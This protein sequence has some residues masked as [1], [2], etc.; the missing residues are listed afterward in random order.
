MTY[1]DDIAG[2][3]DNLHKKEQLAKLAVIKRLDIIKPEDTLLDVGCGTGFSLDFFTVKDAVGIDPAKKLLA[4]YE[5]TKKTIVA[6]AEHLPFADDSFDVIISITAVQ[7]FEN[8][9]KGLE[10]MLRVGKERFIITCLQS[11]PQVEKI[12]SRIDKV[13][14]NFNIHV[15]DEGKERFFVITL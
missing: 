7:N 9:K 3:Y 13:F 1:Y 8:I 6:T 4:L 5:G 12:E 14:F 15:S 10:E 2:G 11:S